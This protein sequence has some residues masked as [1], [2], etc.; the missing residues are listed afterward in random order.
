MLGFRDYFSL[1]LLQV[2][3][4]K[5]H[6]KETHRRSYARLGESEGLACVCTA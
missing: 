5:F 2:K 3:R 6:V 1:V 4:M